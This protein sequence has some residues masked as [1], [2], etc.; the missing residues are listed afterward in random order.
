MS[1][2][3]LYAGLCSSCA[4]PCTVPFRPLQGRTPPCCRSCHG[5]SRPQGRAAGAA[6]DTATAGQAAGAS[7]VPSWGDV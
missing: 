7:G 5:H 4:E 1:G 3:Q 2:Q 6:A